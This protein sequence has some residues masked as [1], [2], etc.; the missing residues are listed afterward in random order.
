MK[1][2][3]IIGAG[4]CGLMAARQ[5]TLKERSV[6]VL[7]ARDRIGGR[8]NTIDG[9]FSTH[10][11]RGAEFVHGKP[12]HT[13]ALIQEAGVQTFPTEGATWE[14]RKGQ[15]QRTSM[16]P[17]TLQM[18]SEALGKL[19]TD[20]TM[21][22]FLDRHFPHPDFP[23]VWEDVRHVIEGFDAADL[24]RISAKAIH[25][26]WSADSE[27]SG[28]RLAGGYSQLCEFL[29]RE[30][31]N[32]GAEIWL[33]S[34]VATIAWTPGRVEVMTT[35]GDRFEARQLIITVPAS[36]LRTGAITFSPATDR[37]HDAVSRIETGGVIKFLLEF[38]RPLWEERLRD[39]GF[40]FS[41]ARVPTWWTQL[42]AGYPI[43]SG[44]LSGPAT[45][46]APRGDNL[47]AMAIESLAYLFDCSPETI[48]RELRAIEIADWSRD[49]FSLGGYAYKTPQTPAALEVLTT[50]VYDTIYFAGE[51]FNVGDEMGTVEAALQSAL[52]V[53]E[54]MME[55]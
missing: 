29:R 22:E 37:W 27:F 38:R 43:L 5:L 15:V 42:P 17:E 47:T 51:A 33:S 32:H 24:D 6:T 4:I 55:G 36:V 16:F 31:T 46:T 25:S 34:P 8:I 11:E 19:G 20:I 45:L 50:P 7:E 28:S 9:R 3:I 54:R 12:K 21:N 10:I 26:E 48:E 41:D 30:A 49:P 1:D 53:V 35:D 18:V 40:I 14:V 2:V 13:Q 52:R 39:A 23:E 44:W